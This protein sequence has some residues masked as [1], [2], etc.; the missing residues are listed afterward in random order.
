MDFLGGILGLGTAALSGGLTG[1]IGVGIKIF[2]GWLT[3]RAEA[4]KMELQF[5]H[6]IAMQDLNMKARG[7]ELE[8]E[9]DIAAEETRQASYGFANVSQPVWTWAASIISLVRPMLTFYLIGL[10]TFVSWRLMEIGTNEARFTNEAVIAAVIYTT[11]T[12]VTW[13]F[14]DRPPSK[15]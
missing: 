9:A 10:T 12:A 6:E 14:G 7:Q 2:G 11:T 5:A 13:W 3:A 15:R 1:L 4:K 8:R